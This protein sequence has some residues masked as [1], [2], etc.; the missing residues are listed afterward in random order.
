[1]AQT[2]LYGLYSEQMYL[3]LI[4]YSLSYVPRLY[5]LSRSAFSPSSNLHLYTI[6]FSQSGSYPITFCDT[7]PK[8]H[9]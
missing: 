1:M 4:K 2:N 7:F 3:L 6:Y 5:S 8:S 9:D